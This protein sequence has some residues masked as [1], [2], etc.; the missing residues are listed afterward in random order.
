MNGSVYGLFPSEEEM[1]FYYL[2]LPSRPTLIACILGC[3]N[4]PV[5]CPSF[6]PRW[7]NLQRT[8]DGLSDLLAV[9][10]PKFLKRS[11]LNLMSLMDF[12]EL[13]E[14]PDYETREIID[15]TDDRS[16]SPQDRRGHDGGQ[17]LT[18]TVIASFTDVARGR[19]PSIPIRAHCKLVTE[20]KQKLGEWLRRS[21][22][23]TDHNL[24]VTI[25]DFIF[26]ATLTQSLSTG[27]QSHRSLANPAF[28]TARPLKQASK[29]EY[30]KVNFTWKDR[31]GAGVA[32]D[33]ISFTPDLEQEEIHDRA[34]AN[35]D[36]YELERVRSH[37]SA[38]TV[39]CARR[40]IKVWAQRG[41]ED[42]PDID[43]QEPQGLQTC[44][45]ARDRVEPAK[46]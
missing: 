18:R 1:E 7:T 42:D 29:L 39:D 27:S 35:Y 41:T 19:E 32:Y 28:A 31:N 9:D 36:H 26:T 5:F 17:T 38:I 14:H 46:K 8:S 34:T 13:L 10:V 11:E 40:A 22:R 24:R 21:S 45:S 37:N 15:L 25:C 23:A 6:G 12:L 4:C 43:V 3:M 20:G 30:L 16:R 33:I 2:G 44:S